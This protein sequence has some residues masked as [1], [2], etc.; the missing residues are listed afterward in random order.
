MYEQYTDLSNSIMHLNRI[1]DYATLEQYI[2]VPMWVL[3]DMG[4]VH[5]GIWDIGLMKK[6]Q[7]LLHFSDII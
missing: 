7:S 4:Y 1:P 6:K 2:S 3:R 5:C